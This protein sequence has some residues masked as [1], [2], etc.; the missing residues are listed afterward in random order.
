MLAILILLA[1]LTGCGPAAPAPAPT[2]PPAATLPPDFTLLPAFTPAYPC[3]L[4][5]ADVYE[6][7]LCRGERIRETAAAQGTGV[8]FILREYH[9]GTGCYGSITIDMRELLVC[10]QHSGEM[11][12]L[13][14]S[15]PLERV[16]SDLIPSPDSAWL[17]FTTLAMAGA[18]DAGG[19]G[20]AIRP[21]VYRVSADGTRFERLDTTG[22]PEFAVGAQGLRWTEDGVWLELSLWDGRAD[23]WY[24]YCLRADGS[25]LYMPQ[26][27]ASPCG[28]LPAEGQGLEL[29]LTDG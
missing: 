27:S 16:T 1:A 11:R 10:D 15:S 5:E 13:T 18:D 23:G 6:A 4:R 14:S 12:S 3:E 25:G 28:S 8:L 19:E 22:L 7:P 26:R 17:A 29:P 20:G 9:L 21:R 2:P 24:V